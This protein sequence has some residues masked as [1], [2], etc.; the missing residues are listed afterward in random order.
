MTTTSVASLLRQYD[1]PGPRYTSYPTAVE[2]NE[3]FDEAAYRGRLEAASAVDAPLSLYTHLPFCEARCSYCGC[4]VIIT[5]KREVAVR[6]LAYLER[7]IALL[8]EHLGPRR[9]IVQHHWGGGTPTYLSPDQMQ[10]LHDTVSR[11]F[12][13]DADAEKA[14]EIDPRVTTHE[15]LDLL[16]ALGF[17]RLSMG[18]QDFTPEVQEAINRHQ[19]ERQTRELYEYARSI[20]FDSINVDLIYGLPEQK[21]DTFART[22]DAVV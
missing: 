15:Q 20:G 2:F 3:S 1:R 5:Q 8:A 21:L 10:R 22:L 6:Y 12:E 18:V 11:Y 17:N 13:F 16:R 9:R 7:E 4:M 14:I 19:T